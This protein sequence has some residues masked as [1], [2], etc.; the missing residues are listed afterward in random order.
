MPIHKE[1]ITGFLERL[2]VNLDSEQ[3]E[4]RLAPKHG[5]FK[6]RLRHSKTLDKNSIEKHWKILRE[7]TDLTEE[8]QAILA[9]GDS[10]EQIE[11]YSKNIENCIGTIKLP[12]GIAG[13]LRING[14]FA[15]GD[16]YLPLATTEAALVASYARGSQLITDA[17]GCTT[18]ILNEGI[19]RSPGFIFKNLF[20]A[21]QFALWANSQFDI[22]KQVAEATTRFGK[23]V[24]VRTT[25]E[26]N[27]VYLNFDYYTGDASGQNMA[28]IASAAILEHIKQ[29]TP[30]QPKYSF[31][32]ANLS[33]DK[34]ASALSYLSVRGKKVSAEVRLEKT[35]VKRYLHTSPETM[36][37][38]WRM[39]ALG[40]VMSGS[41]GTQAH[42]ANGLTALYIA[43][44]QDVACVSES[45]IGVTR[46]ELTEEKDLYAAV[47]LP[48]IV[49][50][51]VGGGTKLPSQSVGLKL[52]GLQGAGK[53]HALA[54]VCAACCLA[55]ELSIM[56]ALCAG[57]FT[58]AHERLARGSKNTK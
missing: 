32:E 41:I 28:T 18:V 48:N 20:E 27:H 4:K 56:G 31:V 51:T 49:V 14:L 34:K 45:S 10:L 5:E 42:Y 58:S 13:P 21:S 46:L 8:D 2:S 19:T 1:K 9:D 16:Y 3:L 52:L 7:Q 15:Q 12:L 37:E 53:V 6:P 38:Y 40:G 11:A 47:T 44:G 23:L 57:D 39:A 50:G 33:G 17:G 24:D 36:V 54:E 25:V 29:N 43:T 26:G 30:I 22:F 35:L 55:G